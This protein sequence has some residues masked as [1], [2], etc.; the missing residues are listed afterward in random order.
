MINQKWLV[1]IQD[2]SKILN[3]LSVLRAEVALLRA[4]N[5]L[6][7][8]E[9]AVL[10]Q[11]NG[12]LKKRLGKDS[13]NSSKP[14]SSDSIFERSKR[15][16]KTTKNK[17]KPGG[18]AG[19]KGSKLKKFA[20]VDFHLDHSINQCCNCNGYELEMVNKQIR[21]IVDIPEPKIEVTEHTVYEYNCIGC[22]ERICSALYDE[23]TQ[24]VQYGPRIKSLVSY[25][26][27]YQL[28]PYKR[29]TELIYDLY[30]HKI[31]QGSISNFNSLLS[32]RLSQFMDSLKGFF[33]NTAP[34]IHSDETG[35]IVSKALHWMH[36]ISDSNKTLLQGHKKRGSEA[37]NEIGVLDKA[38]GICI[39]DRFV[40]Y[41]QYDQMQHGLCNAHL[42]RELKALE[43]D[44]EFKLDWPTQIKKTLLKTKEY[45]D[46]KELPKKRAKRLQSKYEK[47]L[48]DQRPYYSQIEKERKKKNNRPKRT[49]DHNLY[50]AMWKY[51]KEVLLFMHNQVV[52]FDNNQAERD[53]RMC[54]VKMKI[55]NQF[56]TI[57]WMNVYARIRSL[58]STAGKQQINIFK[59]ILD[60]HKDPKSVII[61]AV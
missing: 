23:L 4:E 33:I 17:R 15:I 48:R 16:S 46:K 22:G 7:K 59:C 57:E 27:V 39:H 13:S 5:V 28:I 53:L 41:F 20:F 58:I 18:Q 1:I 56:K 36:V 37:I 35:S 54:K 38:K 55:S 42:L 52:P 50:N 47:I 49:S 21:Q 44:I 9:N 12:E 2:L 31:S 43:K 24:E 30:G 8:Q 11:E 29:L 14:P 34:V 51:R 6:L 60:V 3:E 10:R 61:L 40:S 26:N 45:K 32:N 25:L 19:H